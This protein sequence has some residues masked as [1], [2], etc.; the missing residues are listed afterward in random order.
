MNFP[1]RRA[2]ILSLIASFPMISSAQKVKVGYDKGTDFRK[3][4]SYTWAKPTTEPSRPLLHWNIVSW[5][6]ANLNAKGLAQMQNNGDLIL[7][8][9]GGVGLGFNVVAGTPILSTLGGQPAALDATMWTGTSGSGN[10]MA[11]YVAEGTL[12][13]TFVDRAA[14]KVVWTGTVSQKL[15]LERKNKSLE[16]VE[17][18]I[19]KLLKQFPPTKK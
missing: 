6:D 19:T 1:L 12:I 5:V 13:L 18:S 2:C 4:K 3:F 14:N 9:E 7:V 8:P 15:D 10:L 17:K 11:P 16:L